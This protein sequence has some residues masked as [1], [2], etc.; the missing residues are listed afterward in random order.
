MPM[1]PAAVAAFDDVDETGAV[2]GIELLST[3]KIA[4]IVEGQFL[5]IARP[6]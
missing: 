2:A 5:R 6:T 1:R 4:V 3:V